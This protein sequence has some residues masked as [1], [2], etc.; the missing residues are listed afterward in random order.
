MKLKGIP[1]KIPPDVAALDFQYPSF[2]HNVQVATP[3]G[4][5]SGLPNPLSMQTYRPM[6]VAELSNFPRAQHLACGI[7]NNIICFVTD[8]NLN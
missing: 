5:F 2:R 6:S 7:V 1:A 4:T 8:L 3:S